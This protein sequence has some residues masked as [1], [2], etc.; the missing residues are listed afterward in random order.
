VVGDASNLQVTIGGVNAPVQSVISSGASQTNLGSVIVQVP[1]G[2]AGGGPKDVTLSTV[3]GT[4]TLPKAFSYEPEYSLYDL[5]DQ[6]ITWMTYDRNRRR[7]YLSAGDHV[8]VFSLNSRTFL[9]PI[10]LVSLGGGKHSEGLAV[11]KDG[12]Q[13]AIA[14][15]ADRS[16]TV[17]NPDDLSTARAFNIF[18]PTLT[19]DYVGADNEPYGITFI[20]NG[21]L[22]VGI[23]DSINGLTQQ[24]TQLGRLIDLDVTTGALAAVAKQSITTTGFRFSPL[25]LLT[26]AT[27]NVFFTSTIGSTGDSDTRIDFSTGETLQSSAP[28]Y[29]YSDFDYSAGI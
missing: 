2:V 9:Q 25:E 18:D 21:H 19:Q 22:Y 28:V 10:S 11:S 14:N 24:I 16:V 4:S 6:N 29:A 15:S 20:K 17:V 7:V 23:A 5:P 12:S 13:L 1:P 26:D 3:N 27:G 8:D